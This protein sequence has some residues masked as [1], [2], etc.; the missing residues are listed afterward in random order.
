MIRALVVHPGTQHSH[1]LAVELHRL[2][3]LSELHTGFAVPSGGT[4]ERVFNLAPVSWQRRVANR[5]VEELPSRLVSLQPFLESAAIV[6]M[7]EGH[8]NQAVLHCRNERFQRSVPHRAIEAADVVIGFDTSSWIL[9]ERCRN[10]GK[11]LVLV[12]TIGHPDSKKSVLDEITVR[13]P[14]W[15]VTNEPRLSVVREAEQ[16]EH[17]GA[18]AIIASSS[19]TRQTL[20]Q[21]GVVQN[22][23]RV[24]PHGVD[25][26]RFS[27]AQSVRA[28]S[29]T[30][31]FVFVG[32][33]DARKGVP[34]LLEAWLQLRAQSAELWLVGPAAP[35]IK[36][37]LPELSGVRYFGAVPQTE[38]P[39]ILLQDAGDL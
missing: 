39:G 26:D 27:A 32:I 11:P 17:D 6:R 12:Q 19:F 5:R 38:L 3:A 35:H 23:I 33:V 21:N 28:G 36:S 16:Q 15:S 4:L 37:L 13:F 34:L 18:T 20:I 9:A 30:F 22:K 24:I 2:N 10:A 1:H 29:H 31:R 7:R 8:E 14:Q 25:L